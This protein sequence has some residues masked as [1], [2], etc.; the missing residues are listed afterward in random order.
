[1]RFA[2]MPFALAAKQIRNGVATETVFGCPLSGAD[3]I[4]P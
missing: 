2:A 4:C 1:M 3:A